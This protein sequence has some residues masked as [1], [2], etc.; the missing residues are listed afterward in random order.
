MARQ[1]PYAEAHRV[2]GLTEMSGFPFVKGKCHRWF[3]VVLWSSGLS[4]QTCLVLSP[5]TVTSGTASWNLSLDSAPGTEPAAVQWTFQYSNSDI[6]DLTVDEGPVLTSAGKTVMCAGDAAA[7]TCLTVGANTKTIAN[8]TI[9]RLT[10]VLAS[11]IATATI[12][13]KSSLGAS[14][15][16]YVIPVSPKVILG[17]GTDVSSSCRP[18][19][20]KS[21][22][23]AK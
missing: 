22:L 6:K 18:Q 3:A 7:Y 10:G 15:D 20:Q 4:G 1:M 17:S 23:S 16:G 12:L 9:A 13:I 14:T 19:P 21:S 8:G 11:S 5:P 2:Q